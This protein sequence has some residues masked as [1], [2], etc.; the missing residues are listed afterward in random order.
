MKE[1]KALKKFQ[2][3]SIERIFKT[4]AYNILEDAYMSGFNENYMTDTYDRRQLVNFLLPIIRKEE[5]ER[6]RK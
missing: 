4:N 6:Y 1:N 3:T 2:K 5:R